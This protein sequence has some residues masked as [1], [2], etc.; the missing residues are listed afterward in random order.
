MEK[1]ILQR[2]S[3]VMDFK[4]LSISEFARQ[5]SAPQTTISNIFNRNSNVNSNILEAILT[6][7][8]DI[9]AE[10]LTTGSGSMLKQIPP[11]QF[12][13]LLSTLTLNSTK[14][15]TSPEA[16]LQRI[17]ELLYIT[18]K[19]QS[20]FAELTGINPKTLNQQLKGKRALSL[21]TVLAIISSI[22]DIS[23]NW[24]MTGCGEAIISR[25]QPTNKKESH[26]EKLIQRIQEKYNLTNEEIIEKT[27]ID[28]YEFY[29]VISGMIP[30]GNTITDKIIAAFPEVNRQ[31]L[32]TGTSEMFIEEKAS[33]KA[34]QIEELLEVIKKQSAQIEELLRLLENK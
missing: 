24:L 23:V 1:S 13:D 14:P 19:N 31:Y 26:I 10:W 2:I 4:N 3:R 9:S 16:I 25:Q 8:T 34:P 5:I 32:E 17:K 20:G 15:D 30:I 29:G 28:P 18:G 6:T 11:E 12:P 33:G 7:F 27:E 22:E 21:E